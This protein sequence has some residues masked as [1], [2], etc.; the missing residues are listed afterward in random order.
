MST[1]S[2]RQTTEENLG[3]RPRPNI[4]IRRLKEEKFY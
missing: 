2:S 3:E 1:P 4:G